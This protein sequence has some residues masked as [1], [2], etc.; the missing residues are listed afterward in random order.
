MPEQDLRSE[1]REYH[2]DGL[3]LSQLQSDPVK[4]FSV[5]FDEAGRVIKEDVT[6]MTLATVNGQG[7]PAARIVLLK[8]FDQ[9]NGF[10]WYTDYRSAK[11]Q[12][13][14]E[15]PKAALLFYWQALNRQV[16]IEGAVARLP[17][18]LNAEYFHE[19]PR[20]SQVSAAISKQSAVVVSREILEQ[21]V[22]L[23]EENHPVEVPCPESWG[24]YVLKPTLFEFWQGRES[25]LHDRFQYW[26]GKR[27]WQVDRLQP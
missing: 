6:A 24:G 12:D 7:Q 10:S 23:C 16:R 26:L 11:G 20:G 3:T 1:R 17:L 8:H 9:D 5:W 25:R 15:N 14:A 4:Q 2:A 19:R 27:G 22:A 21:R 13:L 18:E